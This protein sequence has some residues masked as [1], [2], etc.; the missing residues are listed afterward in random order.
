MPSRMFTLRL[1]PA[2]A[3]LE[4]V[5][6]KLGLGAGE[7]DEAFGVVAVDPERQL[8]AVKADDAVADKLEGAGHVGFSNP[9]IEP[10]GPPK[11]K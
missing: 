1:E 9:R 11:A 2:E 6:R 5:R 10:F 8:Y 3:T 7:L 4:G